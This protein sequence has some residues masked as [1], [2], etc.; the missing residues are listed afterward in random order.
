VTSEQFVAEVWPALATR[1]ALAA[2][3]H[4]SIE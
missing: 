1:V 4:R 3:V 2:V